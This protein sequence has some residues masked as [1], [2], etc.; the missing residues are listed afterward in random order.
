M[1][2]EDFLQEGASRWALECRKGF[3]TEK[4]FR[5]ILRGKREQTLGSDSYTQHHFG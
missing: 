2:L 1:Q 4:G 5:V 3:R